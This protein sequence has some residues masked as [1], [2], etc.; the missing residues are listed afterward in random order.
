MSLRS[1]AVAC[2]LLALTPLFAVPYVSGHD[3]Q[4]RPMTGLTL[5]R[6]PLVLLEENFDQGHANW[7]LTNYQQNLYEVTDLSTFNLRPH[8]GTGS[9]VLAWKGPSSDTAWELIARPVVVPAGHA[10]T[11]SFWCRH[12][13]ESVVNLGLNGRYESQIRWL[14]ARNAVV[15][16]QPIS[17]PQSTPQW[18]EVVLH[19][20]VPRDAVRAELHFG[21]DR[22]KIK[23]GHYFALDD[24]TFETPSTTRYQP[25]GE[26]RSRPLRIQPG[27]DFTVRAD[28]PTGT[29][30][31]IQLRTAP[32]MKV[33]GDNTPGAWSNWIGP[34]GTPNSFYPATG[35]HLPPAHPG[36]TWAEYR[37]LLA[38]TNQTITPAVH[39]VNFGTPDTEW[40]GPDTTPPIFK[41]ISPGRTGDASAPLVFA[42]SD[43]GGV[44]I[45]PSTL[46]LTLDSRPLTT[47]II[48]RTNGEVS[49]TPPAPLAP[50]TAINDLSRWAI[51][52][53]HNLLT[54]TPGAPRLAG[55][56][57]TMVVKGPPVRTDT[58]FTLTSP[59]VAVEGGAA[60]YL[61]IWSIHS[62]PL[63]RIGAGM[64]PWHSSVIWYDAQMHQL[65]KRA[66]F[67]LGPAA[68]TWNESDITLTA[69]ADAR[70]AR[71]QLGWN[72]PSISGNDRVAFADVALEGPHP[73]TAPVPNLHRFTLRAADW[74]GNRLHDEMWLLIKAPKTQEVVSLRD[75]GMTLL[76][77]KPFFPIG[78]YN[79]WQQPKRNQSLEAILQE[80][81]D[82]G[83]NTV[84]SYHDD[85]TSE[86][87]EF[88]TA[89]NR[90]GLKVLVPGNSGPNAPNV[91]D[92]IDDAALEA[93]EPALLAWYLADDTSRHI[94]PDEL[95]HLHR[96]LRDI[97]PAHL[98]T[99]A[100][101]VGDPNLPTT[102][103]FIKAVDAYMP[104]I[105]PIRTNKPDEV[106]A[107]IRDME[108]IH[109]LQ[110]QI[111]PPQR[112]IWA[113]L[114]AYQG[115]GW[116]RFPTAVE[117]R[118]MVYLALIHG[119]NGIVYY[120]Y[121]GGGSNFGASDNPEY[122]TFVKKLTGEVAQL[123]DVLTERESAEKPGAHILNGPNLD[124]RGYPS[125]NL[126]LL[127]HGD[128]W[129]LLA[130]NSANAPLHVR[131]SAPNV[132]G[133]VTVDFEGRT[134]TGAGT[135]TD[136]FAPYA[137]HVYQWAAR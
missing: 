51:H 100:D 114:Q 6:Q 29:S 9:L 40:T 52:N 92:I 68:D 10:Y 32:D 39:E 15:G 72:P 61:R 79:V 118:A 115:W 107:V 59:T 106:P 105:Y 30:V 125:L 67:N 97:D 33:Y 20:I 63:E 96:A 5:A 54:I 119:A 121:T 47:G 116:P 76:D 78:I 80:L 65:P 44:G 69:P 22:P 26:L 11:L 71:V 2:C 16:A 84:Q 45:D 95:E 101:E 99:Q 108:N 73:L 13:L 37:L 21:F 41:R 112:T 110:T 42:L 91:T 12:S 103:P 57:P 3:I 58:A 74:A 55:G 129:Y 94:T 130:A 64:P 134:V 135:I 46:T 75:D 132:N 49:Y 35:G 123:Q 131:I 127:R 7:T 14:D 25:A 56:A 28:V 77:G 18:T 137:V 86:F 136:D 88:Y 133:N 66:P 117:T 120:T 87:E 60:Y 126:R 109:L 34:D 122:W 31:K 85:R 98:T 83:F 70:G 104:E 102:A 90:H 53:F 128:Q 62:M 1:L 17:Y 50:L 48:L 23:E 38:T 8:S 24:I 19:G 81:H 124:A 43:Q 82:A 36:D 93:N 4:F 111:G 89:T 113:I 27:G